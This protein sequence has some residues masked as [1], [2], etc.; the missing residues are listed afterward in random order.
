M[1]CDRLEN[2]PHYR[3]MLPALDAVIDFAAAHDCAAL[4][5]GRTDIDGDRAFVNV[6]EFDLLSSNNW[7]CH[8][9]YADL[10]LSLSGGE[11]IGYVPVSTLT[12]WQAWNGDIRFSA[13]PDVGIPLKLEAGQFALLFP[14]DA[15]KPCLGEGH[16]RKAVFKLAMA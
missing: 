15:H 11:T 9:R 6:Q 13:N 14:W 16:G 10:Q 7:E 12:D 4:P 8:A 1:I 5:L 2:L 3:G